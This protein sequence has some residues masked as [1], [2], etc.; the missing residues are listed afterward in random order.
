MEHFKIMNEISDGNL[1]HAEDMVNA[2]QAGAGIALGAVR[3]CA[4]PYFWIHMISMR[5]VR[6]LE[7]NIRSLLMRIIL[8]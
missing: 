2:G 3:I 5:C 8:K 6:V 4:I 7:K 1:Y